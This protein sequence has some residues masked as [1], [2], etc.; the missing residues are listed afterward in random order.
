MRRLDHR[1][2]SLKR[3]LR[4]DSKVVQVTLPLLQFAGRLEEEREG[5]PANYLVPRALRRSILI[6]RA[7]CWVVIFPDEYPPGN[8]TR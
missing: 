7:G 6:G 2:I 5:T 1:W 4:R 8:P 3:T